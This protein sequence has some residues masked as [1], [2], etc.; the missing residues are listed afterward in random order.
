MKDLQQLQ[1]KNNEPK[2][3]GGNPHLKKKTFGTPLM[4]PGEKRPAV[5]YEDKIKEL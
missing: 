2:V 3:N 5:N 4:S 1:K